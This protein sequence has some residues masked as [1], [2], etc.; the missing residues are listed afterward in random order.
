M[1]QSLGPNVKRKTVCWFV[2]RCG[3]GLRVILFVRLF[4]GSFVGAFVGVGL[5]YGLNIRVI[6]RSC[7][8]YLLF[9]LS[10]CLLFG[11]R[12]ARGFAG[13]YAS[14]HV[15]WRADG[16]PFMSLVCLFSC[17]LNHQ[18]ICVVVQWCLCQFICQSVCS[19]VCPFVIGLFVSAVTGLFISLKHSCI[20]EEIL[21]PFHPPRRHTMA[22]LNSAIDP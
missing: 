15:V 10:I 11:W 14:W 19:F 6:V 8:C 18:F 12:V 9:H 13:R 21:C 7:I 4:I 5:V 17:G 1:V 16:L 22:Y 3:C 2:S 20:P